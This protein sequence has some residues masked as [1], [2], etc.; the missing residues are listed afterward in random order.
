[1]AVLP[2]RPYRGVPNNSGGACTDTPR[3]PQNCFSLCQNTISLE[4]GF[5]FIFSLLEATKRDQESCERCVGTATVSGPVPRIFRPR[6]VKKAMN[7]ERVARR[8]GL[9]LFLDKA[10]IDKARIDKARIDKMIW[11][12][13]RRVFDS[14]CE[15]VQG[16]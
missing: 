12:L 11:I 16:L 10:R 7:K 13:A 2:L 9:T 15:L 4:P 1:M 14:H 5:L 6:V 8:I 3:P